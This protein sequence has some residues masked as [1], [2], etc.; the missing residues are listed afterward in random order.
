[1][2]IRK[3]HTKSS[4]QIKNGDLFEI[5]LI[6]T[7]GGRAPKP[8]KEDIKRLKYVGKYYHAKSIILAE[9]QRGNKLNINKLQNNNWCQINANEIF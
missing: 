6:Q 3:N 7:K 2:A 8:T 9:W 4:K 1:M 5:I